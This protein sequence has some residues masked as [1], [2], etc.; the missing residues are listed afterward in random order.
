MQVATID[1]TSAAGKRRKSASATSEQVLYEALRRAI[2]E[3][4]LAPATPLDKSTL[5]RL[6]GLS[7]PQVQRALNRLA[8]E[9]AVELPTSRLAHVIR[10]SAQRASQLLQARLPVEAQ[11]IQLLALQRKAPALEPLHEWV[12]RQRDCLQRNDHIGLLDSV[13][14]VH[15]Y[16]ATLANNPWL[17][18]FLARLLQQTALFIAL[19]RTRAYDSRAC[20]EQQRL[21][22]RLAE[23]DNAGAHMLMERHLRDLFARLHFTP[24]P[25]RR[26]VDCL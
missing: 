23:G 18:D 4:R 15:L 7:N 26:P 19:S 6:F 20:D 5:A 9:G 13:N 17:R 16:L 10:P 11:I 3:R 25:Y 2:L 12:Q 14:A 1:N 21:I 22:E 24:P 8:L